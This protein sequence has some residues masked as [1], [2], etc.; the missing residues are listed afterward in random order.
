[1]KKVAFITLLYV[2]F[3][4]WLFCTTSD[5]A[6]RFAG[7][8]VGLCVYG[9]LVGTAMDLSRESY[10]RMNPDRF[11]ADDAGKIFVIKYLEGEKVALVPWGYT[12]YGIGEQEMT[13]RYY[14]LEQIPESLREVGVVFKIGPRITF[15]KVTVNGYKN[16][17]KKP[18]EVSSEQFV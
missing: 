9:V 3:L 7:T 6:S 17:S 8:L 4:V 18:F 11:T 5:G 15:N 2:G 10:S 16:K 13:S 1:M 12:D 14:F